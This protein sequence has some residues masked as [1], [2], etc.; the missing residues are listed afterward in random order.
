M[1]NIFY[2]LSPD[3]DPEWSEKPEIWTGDV[4]F[5]FLDLISE[6]LVQNIDCCPNVFLGGAL[7]EL[8]TIFKKIK[9]LYFSLEMESF[10]LIF[11]LFLFPFL[12][13][14]S[15]RDL[16]VNIHTSRTGTT[17]V[18]Y[19]NRSNFISLQKRL[20]SKNWGLTALVFVDLVFLDRLASRSLS[21]YLAYLEMSYVFLVA[22][23]TCPSSYQ[24]K[25]SF[26]PPY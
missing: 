25:Q 16:Y 2:F 20:L 18:S 4:L 1:S 26:F 15:P 7:V 8:H 17:L 9:L 13:F 19:S 14:L 6:W 3:I 24:W 21:Y 12:A 10:I 5:Y 11:F 23:A 22:E